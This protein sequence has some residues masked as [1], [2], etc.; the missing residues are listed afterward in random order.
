MSRVRI[1]NSD[2]EVTAVK[3]NLK[4][5]RC[6]QKN[7]VTL[8]AEASY[9]VK[10][11]DMENRGMKVF[12]RRFRDK[13]SKIRSHL[14]INE[15]SRL[16]DLEADGRLSPPQNTVNTTATLRI[17]DAE[18]RLKLQGREHLR[19]TKSA[20]TS[21]NL[22]MS[23]EN[24]INSVLSGSYD[25]HLNGSRESIAV[26]QKRPSTIAW[27]SKLNGS[28]E[29]VSSR[30]PSRDMI[31]KT[32]PAKTKS[33]DAPHKRKSIANSEED[34]AC[35]TS[36]VDNC[37]DSEQLETQWKIP[38]CSS[39]NIVYGEE[40]KTSTSNKPETNTPEISEKPINEQRVMRLSQN[41]IE[42]GNLNSPRIINK[43]SV[44][45]VESE[46]ED[47]TEENKIEQENVINGQRLDDNEHV[48]ENALKDYEQKQNTDITDM[49][50]NRRISLVDNLDGCEV[51]NE[52]NEQSVDVSKPISP[53]HNLHDLKLEP[54]VQKHKK[55]EHKDK[56]NEPMQKQNDP[57]HK[58]DDTKQKQN[59]SKRKQDENKH[60]CH[61]HAH[62]DKKRGHVQS[63]NNFNSNTKT[64]SETSR[65]VKSSNKPAVP[66]TNLSKSANCKTPTS[67]RGR[68]KSTNVSPERRSLSAAGKV[69]NVATMTKQYSCHN[70]D[71]EAAR[72]D[73]RASLS[74]QDGLFCFGDDPYEERR[75]LMIMDEHSRFVIL[76]HKKEEYLERIE[77]YIR[78]QML[79]SSTTYDDH[80]EGK[81]QK[82]PKDIWDELKKCRYLRK[83]DEEDIDLS[84]VVTLASEQLKNKQGLKY[85]PLFKKQ[86]SKKT[87]IIDPEES[88]EPPPS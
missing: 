88:V 26:L 60:R 69:S 28:R 64:G 6:L 25:S 27:D 78:L 7:L 17:A 73:K 48:E 29:N 59:E 72:M 49:C 56:Q 81:R 42:T 83:D 31:D 65:S 36:K 77:E 41:F 57:K 68:A 10:L 66:R 52:R 61:E 79:G 8:D 1:L 82:S 62:N 70:Y 75:Q 16:R 24:P 80:M 58:Q 44:S 32:R 15:I 76:L 54:D 34:F 3:F 55:I 39:I 85:K 45:Q 21:R 12:Y 5:Q 51:L 2:K 67:Q 18:K 74:I 84:T 4:E 14:K 22:A 33:H 19:K 46:V 23:K 87:I 38:K 43:T 71:K 20:F 40:I 37:M 9:S 53:E 47:K 63:Q 13:V 86:K 30:R 35:L 50:S 11:I